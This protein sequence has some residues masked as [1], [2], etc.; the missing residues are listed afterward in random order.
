MTT[1]GGGDARG[2]RGTG[3][4]EDEYT[5]LCGAD[6]WRELPSVAISA[7]GCHSE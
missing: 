4:T 7:L 1:A 3:T 6:S 2:Y 5:V